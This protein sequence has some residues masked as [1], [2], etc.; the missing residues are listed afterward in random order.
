MAI[1]LK[2]A[3]PANAPT[4]AIL[5][6][7]LFREIMDATGGADFSFDPQETTGR[8]EDMLERQV[9]FAIIAWEG[10]QPVGLWPACA[11][12]TPCMPGAIL[13]QFPS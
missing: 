4:V 6:G 13:A 12:A 7:E 10:S 8:A 1:I 5:V 2:P 9:Y 3:G 11:R